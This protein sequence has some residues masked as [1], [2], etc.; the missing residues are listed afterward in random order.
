MGIAE[1][2]HN[3]PGRRDRRR[4]A[5]LRARAAESEQRQEHTAWAC[6]HRL[7]ACPSP[8]ACELAGLCLGAE[9]DLHE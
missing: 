2:D 8:V 9:G 3:R 5:R 7:G 6:K 1:R 4:V